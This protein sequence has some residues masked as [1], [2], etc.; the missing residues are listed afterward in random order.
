MYSK[1]KTSF[2]DSISCVPK[3]LLHLTN[4]IFTLYLFYVRGQAK[5][6]IGRVKKNKVL[7]WIAGTSLQAAR[8]RNHFPPY[9]HCIRVGGIQITHIDIPEIARFTI[10]RFLGVLWIF[11]PSQISVRYFPKGIFLSATSQVSISQV[12]T[13][14][15]WNFPSGNFP[16]VRLGPLRRRR[17][18][19][20][21]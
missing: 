5:N 15:M 7:P 3:I 8:P 21:A 16:K 13:S 2:A 14:Q 11:L 20:G 19:W 6:I 4:F 1:S 10:Y 12:T 18:Q 9:K 17:P